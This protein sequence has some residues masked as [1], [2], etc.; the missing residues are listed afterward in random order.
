MKLITAFV[1]IVGLIELAI[2][3]SSWIQIRRGAHVNE[4]PRVPL[5]IAICAFLVAIVPNIA[6]CRHGESVGHQVLAVAAALAFLAYA[7][8]LEVR[9]ARCRERVDACCCGVDA[10]A[11]APIM[12]YTYDGV[13]HMGLALQVFGRA[14]LQREFAARKGE[15]M[16]VYVDP[17]HP[18][19]FMC[20][21]HRGRG[22]WAVLVAVFFV[23]IAF[24]VPGFTL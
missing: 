21:R 2:A 19:R 3:V 4:R 12:R 1:F 17:D 24:F 15:T 14:T 16:D 13:E 22:L 18:E 10:G 20:S 23:V 8:V 9:V 11:H 5:A 7:T 6:A